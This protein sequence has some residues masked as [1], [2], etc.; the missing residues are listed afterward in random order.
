MWKILP[1]FQVVI[2]PKCFLQYRNAIAKDTFEGIKRGEIKT[3]DNLII[4]ADNFTYQKNENTINATG[5]VIIVDKINKY[6][7]FSEYIFYNKNSEEIFSKGK[8]KINLE[9]KY[10]VSSS[11]IYLDRNNL[12]LFSKEKASIKTNKGMI[13]EFSDFRYLINEDLAA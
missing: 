1:V 10:I 11:N 4:K 5:N 13:Y 2:I 12:E 6:T 9:P 7:I 3:S 8:T